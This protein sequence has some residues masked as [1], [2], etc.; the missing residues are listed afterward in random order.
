MYNEDDDLFMGGD[1]DS[2]CVDC[3]AEL[4]GDEEEY[5]S[6]CQEVLTA[7][8]DQMY[9]NVVNTLHSNGVPLL[10]EDEGIDDDDLEF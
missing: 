10:D 7:G 2:V 4:V 1:D 9:G 3:G 8:L 6:S 5:C